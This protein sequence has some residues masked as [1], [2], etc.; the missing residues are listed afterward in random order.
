MSHDPSPEHRCSAGVELS[1]EAL[2]ERQAA[3]MQAAGD[4]E[5]PLAQLP[6][7]VEASF[8]S[9][10][11]GLSGSRVCPT[12]TLVRCTPA[13]SHSSSTLMSQT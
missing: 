9:L 8:K 3:A 13:W 11:T 12:A 6:P 10:L 5:Q 2:A 4:Q 7:D 1:D